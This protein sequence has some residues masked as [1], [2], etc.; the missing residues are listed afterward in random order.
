MTVTAGPDVEGALKD[1]FRQQV[2]VL[3]T[4]AGD[5][6]FLT[7]RTGSVF[8]YIVITQIGGGEDTSDAPMDNALIQIDV[9]GRV[10]QLAEADA[11]RKAVRVALVKLSMEGGFD[12]PGKGRLL[13]TAIRDQR[14][15]PEPEAQD[16]DGTV[17]E[18]PRYIITASVSCVASDGP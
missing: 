11:V 3:A 6:T 12:V 7:S 13:G 2:D 1:Y 5:R 18:R 14:R 16:A 4:A 17:G 9:F 8:P 15:F 10:R